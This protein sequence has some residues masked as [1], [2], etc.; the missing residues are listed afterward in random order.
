MEKKRINGIV[1]LKAVLP[2]FVIAW[3]VQFLGK[4]GIMEISDRYIPDWKDIIYVNVI[5][6]A[7]PVFYIISLYLYAYK[8]KQN[9][10][11]WRYLLKRIGQLLTI[12]FLCRIVYFI[13]GIGDLWVTQ[14]GK[15]RNIYHLLFGG[16]DTLLYYLLDLCYLLVFLELFCMMIEKFKLK[17]MKYIFI[18][19][20]VSKFLV[21]FC[22]F[23]PW[24]IRLET[25]RYFSPIGFF[26]YTFIALFLCESHKNDFT[27][28]IPRL[29]VIGASILVVEWIFIPD[30]TYLSNGYSVAL[31]I[32]ARL[33]QA[34]MAT[35]IFIA[36]LGVKRIPG[37]VITFMS[38]ASLYVYCIHQLII[39]G[40]NGCFIQKSK[41]IEFAVVVVITYFISG[42]FVFGK[43]RIYKKINQG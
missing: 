7:V 20:G 32:Y 43:K 1:Y 9:E 17:R 30:A 16:G 22:Y 14:R 31:P 40:I 11:N 34:L 35:A 42:C 38:A 5:N 19:G 15:A 27:K 23:L 4:S 6:L 26:P 25:Q 28:A 39:K 21:V 37:K 41:L 36:C 12:F 8:R 29:L 18:G 24:A 10:S 3:H 33:S 2:L 13:V